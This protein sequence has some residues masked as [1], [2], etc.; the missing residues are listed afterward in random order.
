MLA[1]SHQRPISV[2][3][4]WKCQQLYHIFSISSLPTPSDVI[5][6]ARRPMC[7]P[8]AKSSF[9][10]YFLGSFLIPNVK[11]HQKKLASKAVRFSCKCFLGLL[12]EITSLRVREAWPGI[13]WTAMWMASWSQLILWES[14]MLEWHFSYPSLLKLEV[15]GLDN[16]PH[17]TSHWMQAVHRRYAASHKA[18]GNSQRGFWLRIFG[19]Q[20]GLPHSWRGIWVA[21]NSIHYPQITM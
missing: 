17:L 10:W 7:D 5:F 6:T 2:D 16:S 13:S 4:C 15:W 14:L 12:W 21:H 20:D 3:H 9:R 11:C 8:S 1:T 19:C 18:K